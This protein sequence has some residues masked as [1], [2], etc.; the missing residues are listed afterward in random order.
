MK[1]V[2]LVLACV[3][4]SAYSQCDEKPDVE[5]VC[6]WGSWSVYRKETGKF[7][8]K[9]ID[10]KSCTTVI[11]AFAGI[12]L[13]QKTTS[14][15]TYKDLDL[16][17]FANFTALKQDNPCLTTMLAIGGWNEGSRKYSVMANS[18]QLREDFADSVIAFLAY[19]GFDGVD[20]DWEYP[21][22]RGG[23]K[24]D[25][26]NF[27]S[28]LQALKSRFEKYEL[29]L[30][31]AVS[32]DVDLINTAYV[33]PKLADL[34][35]N[36]NVMAY[37]Y[38]TSESN[39]TGLSSP[40]SKIKDTISHWLKAGLPSKKLY[41]GIPAYAKTFILANESNADIG[42]KVTG[43]GDPGEF[44]QEAGLLAYYEVKSLMNDPSEVATTVD[45]TNY[46]SFAQYWFTFDT[47]ETVTTKVNYAMDQQ[48]GGI[49]F[50]A[51]ELD[52]FNGDYGDK[53]PLLHAITDAI[54]NYKSS[55]SKK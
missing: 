15:D 11:Y 26:E 13:D 17:G 47:P 36:V 46:F 38:V 35:D 4:V 24:E 31:I 6:Y 10:V 53:Y 44:T 23:I 25:G 37:D 43:Q 9:D 14:L 33:V 45:D 29:K 22:T 50:W 51:L 48:L 8:T 28:L 27:I 7:A 18:K 42:A 19:Y 52:D 32:I 41:L 34:V 3:L 1:A 5:V 40:L 55:S 30:S 2:L 49:M 39:V 20:I 12:N 21:T 54:A 16:K